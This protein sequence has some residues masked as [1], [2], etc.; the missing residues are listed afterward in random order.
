MPA[1]DQMRLLLGPFEDGELE[2]H[3]MQDVAF[4]VVSCTECKAILEDYRALGVA[5]RDAAAIPS[6]D[7]L[8]EAVQA[9]IARVRVPIRVRF[10]RYFDSLNQRLA[11]GIAIGAAAA[12]SAVLTV[13]LVSPVARRIVNGAAPTPDTFSAAQPLSVP[14]VK[15]A[16]TANPAA[17]AKA[18]VNQQVDVTPPIDAGNPRAVISSLEADSPSVAVWNE[19]RTDTTVIWV[20]DQP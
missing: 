13:A 18:M 2:P 3:E 17:N 9:R 19:P 16:D 4:H 11:A 8:S 14:T 12:V 6:L 7:G 10:G 1:C 20:P 5:L 15:L